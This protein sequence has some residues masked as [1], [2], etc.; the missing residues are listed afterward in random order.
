MAT[1]ISAHSSKLISESAAV[2]VDE[3]IHALD[4]LR[5]QQPN[6]STAAY[7]SKLPH[8]GLAEILVKAF[9]Q[10]QDDDVHYVEISGSSSLVW[11]IL[12]LFWLNKDKV[13]LFHGSTCLLGPEDSKIRIKPLI[14]N[15]AD[16]E[17]GAPHHKEDNWT[18]KS[19]V[20][21]EPIS[22][23]VKSQDQTNLAYRLDEP[24]FILHLLHAAIT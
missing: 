7:W 6:R 17:V 15:A 16:T 1:V 8:K 19:W 13:G 22:Q 2:A 12:T 24:G 11:I 9:D 5:S 10:L 23:M 18:F 21:G 3:I 20:K 4:T 14:G